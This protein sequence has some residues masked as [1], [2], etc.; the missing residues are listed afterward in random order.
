MPNEPRGV[1]SIIV[2]SFL[3]IGLCTTA[4]P[5]Q[6]EGKRE[7]VTGIGGFFFKS[8]NPKELAKWYETHLGVGKTPGSYGDSP[9]IQEKGPT[10]F[11]PF[12]QDTK[13]FKS[14]AWMLNF[15]VNNLDAMVRQLKESGIQVNV[16]PKV[17]PNGRFGQLEDPEGNPIQL[18]EPST[19][20]SP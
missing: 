10:A 2:L 9:W 5:A 16:D 3:L 20:Q 7:R 11:Q 15:R 6:Q 19:P 13:Y 8:Q 14:K 17:Y 4:V 18:W 1:K 12:P